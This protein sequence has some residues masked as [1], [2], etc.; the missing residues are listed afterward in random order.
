MGYR[1]RR[2]KAGKQHKP[3]TAKEYAERYG[4]GFGRAPTVEVNADL[5]RLVLSEVV[6]GGIDA[7]MDKRAREIITGDTQRISLITAD[8]L[9]AQIGIP[10]TL[11]YPEL[12]A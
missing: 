8:R 5:R 12:A 11:V 3:L 10:L 7:R 1:L 9:C 4:T 6:T 2:E